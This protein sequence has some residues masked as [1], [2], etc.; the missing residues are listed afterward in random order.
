[1]AY[2]SEKLKHGLP[3]REIM[4]ADSLS[5]DTLARMLHSGY[6]SRFVLVNERL[7]TVGQLTETQLENA[8]VQLPRETLLSQLSDSFLRRTG[9]RV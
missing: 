6:Y 4:V 3:V 8:L 5:L 9:G 1:M 7:E 2:R